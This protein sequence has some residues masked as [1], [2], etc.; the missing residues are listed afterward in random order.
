MDLTNAKAVAMVMADAKSEA[1]AEEAKQARAETKTASDARA[2][3]Q[4]IMMKDAMASARNTAV[5]EAEAAAKAAMASARASTAAA[6]WQK[7]KPNSADA[8][9][10]ASREAASH[11]DSNNLPRYVTT[12]LPGG[13]VTY[14]K[15]AATDEFAMA[16]DASDMADGQ[17]T[18]SCKSLS[19]SA[20]D[21][22]CVTACAGRSNC[23]KNI[24]QCEEGMS[25]LQPVDAAEGVSP[26]E[27]VMA[28]AATMSR[29]TQLNGTILDD[30][31]QA[32]SEVKVIYPVR[33]NPH[34]TAATQQQQEPVP[35]V[36]Q[37]QDNE[38]VHMPVTATNHGQMSATQMAAL[39]HGS[40]TSE[41][42]LAPKKEQALAALARATAALVS[43]QTERMSFGGGSERTSAHAEAEK[44]QALAALRAA[45]AALVQPGFDA[46]KPAA[47]A[48]VAEFSC[49]SLVPT[50]TDAWCLATCGS[51][52]GLSC[53]LAMCKCD[54]GEGEGLQMAEPKLLDAGEI[55]VTQAVGAVTN[56]ASELPVITKGAPAKI[57]C[58][59]LVPNANDE[60]CQTVCGS[61]GRCPGNVCRCSHDG[62]CRHSNVSPPATNPDPNPNPNSNPNPN[63]VSRTT[64][65]SSS[66]LCPRTARRRSSAPPP[67]RP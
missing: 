39:Q 7:G 28:P 55:P 64:R 15:V 58:V 18:L 40:P 47:V 23:P 60:W 3:A 48:A 27:A 66:R 4:N 52:K 13:G 65:A 63:Q 29:A 21:Y 24:C 56:G 11:A 53:P 6:F 45:S 51:S 9:A 46:K 34:P 5:A 19:P 12:H 36:Q 2:A 25:K 67:R 57:T 8:Q 30:S 44:Q 38:M 31:I 49:V 10:A 54:G 50:A 42:A 33:T 14:T 20:T 43:S 17:L 41:Q 61:G 22:W 1:V 35:S 59:S 37:Q 62:D 16:N 26:E 32:E